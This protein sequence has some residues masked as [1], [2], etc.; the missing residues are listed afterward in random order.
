M[1]VTLAV[2]HWEGKTPVCIDVL[3]MKTRELL[4]NIKVPNPFDVFMLEMAYLICVSLISST[5]K[6][7]LLSLMV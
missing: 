2:F 3:K 7:L 6:L 1:G 4:M 5:L